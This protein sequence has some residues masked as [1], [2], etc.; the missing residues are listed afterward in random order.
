MTLIAEFYYSR[1]WQSLTCVKGLIDGCKFG[2]LP[3][4]LAIYLGVLKEGDA[5]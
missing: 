1:N 4:D 5:T 2:L 3:D